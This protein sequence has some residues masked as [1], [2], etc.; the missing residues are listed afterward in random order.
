MTKIIRDYQ[1]DFEYTQKNFKSERKTSCAFIFLGGLRFSGVYCEKA[2][3]SIEFLIYRGNT[4][5]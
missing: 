5:D 3:L 2:E 4:Y 1:R